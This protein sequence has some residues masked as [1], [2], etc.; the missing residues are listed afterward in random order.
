MTRSP[1]Y[2]WACWNPVCLWQ[3]SHELIIRFTLTLSEQRPPTAAWFSYN[4][5]GWPPRLPG[6][7]KRLVNSIAHEQTHRRPHPD[8]PMVNLAS[9][10]HNMI[11]SACTRQRDQSGWIHESYVLVP[12]LRAGVLTGSCSDDFNNL[13]DIAESPTRRPTP[14]QRPGLR[15]NPSSWRRKAVAAWKDGTGALRRMNQRRNSHVPSGFEMVAS[16]FSWI[17]VHVRQ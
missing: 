15:Q 7:Q 11:N 9:G 10:L 14:R 13:P 5:T 16:R 2:N 6:L 4:R 17:Y 1:D 8:H 3:V 12:L